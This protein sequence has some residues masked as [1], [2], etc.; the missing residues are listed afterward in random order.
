MLN[1]S[2]YVN[3]FLGSSLF[4]EK[5]NECSTITA[6]GDDFYSTKDNKIQKIVM[7]GGVSLIKDYY[8]ISIN[9]NNFINDM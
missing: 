9:Y 8:K 5:I 6:V 7:G 2:S 3:Y 1:I 4:L